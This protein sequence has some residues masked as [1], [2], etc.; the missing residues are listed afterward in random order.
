MVEKPYCQAETSAGKYSKLAERLNQYGVYRA[1]H[2]DSGYDRDPDSR[3]H[4]E[5]EVDSWANGPLL[6]LE[7]IAPSGDT[8]KPT[9]GNRLCRAIAQAGF[10]PWG[11]RPEKNTTADGREHTGRWMWYL[12]PI[13]DVSDDTSDV[14]DTE[15]ALQEDDGSLTRTADGDLVA[16][17]SEAKAEAVVAEDQ[18]VVEV[19]D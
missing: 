10:V 3:S 6:R 15:F 4:K 8:R 1:D 7:E 5:I 18:E 11:F 19:I 14:Y 12:R 9:I 17:D 13:E 2:F 16:F